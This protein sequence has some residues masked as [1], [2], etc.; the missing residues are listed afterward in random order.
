M[1]DVHYRTCPLCEAMC[2]LEI[3]V[4]GA[5]ITRI[6]GDEA[7]PFSRGHICPKAVGLKDIHADPDRLRH[8]VRRTASGWE[9]I[10]WDTAIAEAARGLR[11]VQA[12]HGPDALGIYIGNPTV[13]NYG[14][15]LFVPALIKAL[16]TRNRFSA[17]SVDQLPH[18]FTAYWMFGHQL[19]LPIPDID[20]TQHMLILGA[21]P[22]VSNGSLMSAPDVKRRLRAISERGGRLVVV[23]PRRSETAEL[24]DE[25]IFIRPG[26]DVLLLLGMLHTLFD[27]QLVSPGRLAELCR[28]LD[29][30]TE[31]VRPYAPER[32]AGPTGIDAATMRRLARD[33]A[34]APAAVVY[35][36]I[37]TSVQRFGGLCNWLINLLNI[38]TGNL[39]RPGGALWTRPAFDVVAAGGKGNW[40]RWRSRVRGLPEFA[41]ELPVAALAEEMRTPGAGQIRGFVTVAGNPALSTPNGAQLDAALAELDFMVAIDFY[42][43][44]TTRHANIILPPTSALEHEHYD[45]TFNVLAI[46]NVAK[47]SPAI[48]APEPDM[49]HDWQI[50]QALAGQ[51]VNP[52]EPVQPLHP[53]KLLARGLRG[54]PWRDTLSLE[55]LQSEPHGVDL[56]AL[57]PSLPQ[58]LATADG[59][60]HCAPE[61]FVQDLAR[62]ERELLDQPASA[63]LVLIGRRQLRSNNSWMHNVERLVRG[64]ER[65]TLL[66][67]PDDAAL[68]QLSAG[69]QVRVTSAVGAI[70]VPLAISAEI[71]PG[72]VSLPHGWGHARPAAQLRV[73][74]EHPGASINDLTDDSAIDLLTGNA[75]LN[76]V[77]VTVAA[78]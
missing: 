13:H 65:C 42:I 2:G 8:P 54:G 7:D 68:R 30:V 27:E 62:V 53:D 38:V 77:A 17:T 48:F 15:L 60:I 9:R 16:G 34:A 12:Q 3:T 56:G 20:R 74:A 24:A 52:D 67:H 14:S 45:V 63:E 47:Y 66:M 19:L 55:R 76:S 31:L 41:G 4:E 40:G 39:D 6:A 70:E 64:A 57:E 35:G 72:V 28:D 75:A 22:A 23:D 59:L 1:P 29:R 61:L 71:M 26:S 5:T 58:R 44:E 21:N 51:L 43:N 32:V 69:Q 37:G 10:D 78:A 11:A 73:A 33:F 36:R 46:R 18:Q 25:H 50:I 49:R